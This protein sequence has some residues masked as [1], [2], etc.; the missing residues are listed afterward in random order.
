MNNKILS[1]LIAL[2]LLSIGVYLFIFRQPAA[3]PVRLN[4]EAPAATSGGNADSEIPGT[5]DLSNEQGVLISNFSFQ[6]K[7]I[8]IKAGTKV[9]WTNDDSV[10]HTV[11]GA[12]G[13]FD[14]QRLA[15][16][17][18]YEFI[19]NDKGTFSYYCIPHPSMTGKIIVE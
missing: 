15:K 3:E 16:G 5:N 13:I 7:E 10:Q 19:F 2:V 12:G 11:T 9:V 4:Q 18:K 6:P 8:R 17:Q 1:G 14:S